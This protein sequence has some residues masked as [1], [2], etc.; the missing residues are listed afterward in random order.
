MK[1]G[2]KFSSMMQEFLV[3][4]NDETTEWFPL[5]NTHCIYGKYSP[6]L[7]HQSAAH[8]QTTMYYMYSTTHTYNFSMKFPKFKFQVWYLEVPYIQFPCS[9]KEEDAHD[10]SSSSSS[11]IETPLLLCLMV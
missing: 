2:K 3:L 10:S 7:P 8:L 11:S 6:Q 4:N 1:K 5:N 9:K